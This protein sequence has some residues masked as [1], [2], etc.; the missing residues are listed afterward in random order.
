MRNFG[1][2]FELFMVSAGRLLQS[3]RVSQEYQYRKDIGYFNLY[4]LVVWQKCSVVSLLVFDAVVLGY[5]AAYL[6]CGQ[7]TSFVYIFCCLN[8]KHS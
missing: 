8:I 6:L 2:Q 5:F 3:V 7:I 1:S 4:G